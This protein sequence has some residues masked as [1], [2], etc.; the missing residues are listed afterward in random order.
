MSESLGFFYA[1]AF[2]GLVY[3]VVMVLVYI[4]YEWRRRKK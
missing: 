1:I 2:G 3:I 4:L